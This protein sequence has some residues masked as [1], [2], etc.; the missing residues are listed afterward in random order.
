VLNRLIHAIEEV[1]TGLTLKLELPRRLQ[2]IKDQCA[3]F[4]EIRNKRLAHSDLKTAMG[5]R[6]ENDPLMMASR[7]HVE[8]ALKAIR[9]FMNAV[10]GHYFDG[11]T[12]Y[13]HVILGPGDGDALIHYL[14]DLRKRREDDP[15][16]RSQ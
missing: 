12:G 8:E 14:E 7:Q 4:R 15:C 5:Q 6:A 9:D 3:V 11:E 10:Q 13:E 1:E 2:G 16:R